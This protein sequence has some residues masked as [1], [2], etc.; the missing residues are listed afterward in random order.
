MGYEARC[1]KRPAAEP[2]IPWWYWTI[3]PDL[4]A[5]EK[6]WQDE[7]DLGSASLGLLLAVASLAR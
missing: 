6:K 3:R 5:W 7:R 4:S 1:P 2:A